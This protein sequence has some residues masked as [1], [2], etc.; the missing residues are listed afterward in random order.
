MFLIGSQRLILLKHIAI[1]IEIVIPYRQIIK[2][3]FFN[4]TKHDFCHG[5][6]DKYMRS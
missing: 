5:N 3:F 4:D 2:R 1:F 6:S